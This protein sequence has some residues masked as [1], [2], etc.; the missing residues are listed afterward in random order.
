MGVIPS[1][2]LFKG[3]LHIL[4]WVLLASLF[5]QGAYKNRFPFKPPQRPFQDKA[6]DELGFWGAS[7]AGWPAGEAR[8]PTR[9]GTA[10]RMR[11][12]RS[13]FCPA[14]TQVKAALSLTWTPLG[15]FEREFLVTTLGSFRHIRFLFTPVERE[16]GGSS[17][18]TLPPH[19]VSFP[20]GSTWFW[21]S[22]AG[23]PFLTH[24]C[25]FGQGSENG[26]P[27]ARPKTSIRGPLVSSSAKVRLP[28]SQLSW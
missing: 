3:Y 18:W 23:F 8:T 5:N 24:K 20:A 19:P 12:T 10:A 21:L 11:G 6:R 16:F 22:D 14:G 1:W 17:A 27:G 28:V 7:P 4:F 15:V 26:Q 9:S 13:R 25:T 2:D